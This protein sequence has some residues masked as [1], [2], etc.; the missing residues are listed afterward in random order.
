MLCQQYLKGALPETIFN[1]WLAEEEH[2][3]L[4]REELQRKARQN[5][6]ALQRQVAQCRSTR[7]TRAHLEHIEPRNS[8]NTSFC[9]QLETLNPVPAFLTPLRT[10][11]GLLGTINPTPKGPSIY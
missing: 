3:L 1:L 5:Q 2:V 8:F 10:G 4:D 6:R 7:S 11:L 9:E